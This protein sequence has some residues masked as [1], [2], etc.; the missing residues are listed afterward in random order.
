MKAQNTYWETIISCPSVNLELFSY[1]LFE[2]SATGV[3]E[4]SSTR[5]K[6]TVK[7]FFEME[8]NPRIHI[9]NAS[10]ES[11]A[12]IQI[13]EIN[14]KEIENWQENWKENFKPLYIGQNFVIRPPWEKISNDKKEIIILPGQGF[15]TGYHE[16]TRLA[17][18]NIEHL[19]KTCAPESVIDVGTGSGILCIATMLLGTKKI[20]AID[21]E[22]ESVS[23]VP[24]NMK[25]S[26]LS[27]EG[28]FIEKMEPHQLK[29]SGELAIA[30]IISEVLISIANDLVRLTNNNG[31]IILSGIL[32]TELDKVLA[33][34]PE[35]VTL[36]R[37]KEEGDWVSVLL[38]KS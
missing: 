24:Q 11:G 27:P 9:N 30:N 6:V 12:D 2:N 15:G 32:Q 1:Y 34:F 8:E 19:Y 36:K 28:C 14:Q 29:A 37:K 23:E 35:S 5:E 7:A 3:E 4:L 17:I 20:T 25:L 22:E 31:Y 26:G 13:M 21:I 10:E 33:A 38:H 18:D 16:S